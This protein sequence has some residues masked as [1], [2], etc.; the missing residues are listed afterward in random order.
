MVLGSIGK[1]TPDQARGAARK[2]LA[3]V[4]LGEDPAAMRS[5]AREMPTFRQ[6][7]ERYLSEEAAAKLKPNTLVNY[8]TNLF[9]HA[10]A[11][12]GNVRRAARQAR[13]QRRDG[14]AW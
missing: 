12:I 3:S 9:R 13:E 14:E 11:F 1:L 7:A 6:C 2:I 10:A 4:A 5:R 8:R